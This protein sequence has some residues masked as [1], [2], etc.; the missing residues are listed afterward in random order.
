MSGRG[1][2][3]KGLGKGGAKRHR[4]ILRD[5]IQ[6]ISKPAIRRLARRGGVKRI[7]GLIYEE[8]RHVLKMFLE[9]VI[10]DATTYTEYAK[11]KTV[12]PLDVVLALK[13]QGHTLYGFGHPTAEKARKRITLASREGDYA[14][15]PIRL[16]S[17]EEEV[18][19]KKVSVKKCP[20]D[21]V[22]QRALD[23]L[24]GNN[25]LSDVIVN[26]SVFLALRNTEWVAYDSF[27][28][29]STRGVW[30][31]PRKA[32][33]YQR[34]KIDINERRFIVP[35]N[36][37]DSHWCAMAVDVPKKKVVFFDSLYHAD[38]ET[39]YMERLKRY[40][41]LAGYKGDVYAFTVETKTDKRQNDGSSCGVYTYMFVRNI[42]QGKAFETNIPKVRREIRNLITKHCSI[43]Q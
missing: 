43:S 23:T 6:G 13:R 29:N 17:D 27:F 25:W 42:A 39:I 36:V 24:N 9:R 35:I 7:G 34:D 30:Q 1:K 28:F 5:N 22:D 11:R 15:N 40:L 10:R 31:D 32:Q 2:G 4:K 18:S 3:K 16:S 21:P 14:S 19:V 20:S 33:R 37:N 26:N 41:T 12:T 8:T 38:R